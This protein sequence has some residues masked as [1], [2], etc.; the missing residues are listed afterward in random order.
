MPDASYTVRTI[1]GTPVVAT[2]EEI[3]VSNA[4]ALSVVLVASV[5]RGHAVVAV[6]MTRTQFCDSVGLNALIRAHQR[7]QAAGGGLRLVVRAPAILRV[8]AVTGTDQIFPLFTNLGDAL[9]ELSANSVR[10]HP[11]RPDPVTARDAVS[12]PWV[13]HLDLTGAQQK[14]CAGQHAGS[15]ASCDG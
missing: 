7:A 11:V 9:A 2:P 14:L 5:D 8:L 15:V 1:R 4:Y 3:D 13:A 12:P 10:P 6:D